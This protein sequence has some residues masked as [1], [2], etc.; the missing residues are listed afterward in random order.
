MK[1]L[2][3]NPNQIHLVNQKGRIY[4]RAWPPLDLANCAA[5]MEQ[6][7]HQ[8]Q[9]I[10]A[11]ALRL[12]ID[13]VFKSANSFDKV[14]IT[15]S[16]LDRWQCP[17]VDIDPFLDTVARFKKHTE[18]IFILGIHGTLKPKELLELTKAKAVVRGEPEI[19]VS[20]ICQGKQLSDIAGVAFMEGSQ[21]KIAEDQKPLDL[22]DLPLPALH[23]LPMDKY[24]YEVLGSHFTLFEGSRGCATKCAFCLLDMYGK[25]L[26]KKSVEKLISEVDYA[27]SN[28]GVKT[29]YFFD[30]EFTVFRNQVMELCDYLIKKKYDFHWTCQTRLDLVDELLLKKMKQA[31]C[32]LIH[33][34]VE[35]GS[36]DLL[37]RVNKKITI[38][39]IEDG[40]RMVHRAN[41]ESACFFMLGFP[42]SDME[43][44]EKTI[45][46]SKRL[47][48]T[49]GLFKPVVPYP[50]T[51]L[52]NKWLKEGNGFSDNGLFPESYQK[53]T[54]LEKLKKAVSHAY[55]GY[56]LRPKY[57][58]SRISK[59]D[60]KSLFRQVKLLLGYF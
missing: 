32:R 17:N 15:S 56:Y 36:D 28:F 11:N 14:F 6:Q 7:G 2:L 46:F 21:I 37:R 16:S 9:I 34:G 19:T 45:K 5:I 43:E 8:V 4:N 55:A 51:A 52:F 25:S 1:I 49:Y 10:D 27:I 23:L 31:G 38:K 13:E 59:G 22:D 29:A 44:I 26:R 24:Y 3:V 50:G 54:D 39:Q 42:D 33:F 47:N 30:L 40:M 57:I 12:S 53:G 35:S 60:L 58:I 18:E 48:P 20:E 41:I